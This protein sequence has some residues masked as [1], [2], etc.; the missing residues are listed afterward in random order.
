MLGRCQCRYQKL[1][2][3]FV[4]FYDGSVEWAPRLQDLRTSNDRIRAQDD[5]KTV[6]LTVKGQKVFEYK[7]QK[8]LSFLNLGRKA[9]WVLKD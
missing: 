2:I 4:S 8:S 9:P 3:N 1:L 5:F 7:L 6:A